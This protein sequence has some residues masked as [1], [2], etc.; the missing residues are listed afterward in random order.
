[1]LFGTAL[2]ALLMLSRIGRRV[3]RLSEQTHEL[4][5]RAEQEFAPKQPPEKQG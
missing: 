5:K 2:V 1:M 4:V 3:D